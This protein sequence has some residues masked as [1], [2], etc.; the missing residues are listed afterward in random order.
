M[1]AHIPQYSAPAV[2]NRFICGNLCGLRNRQENRKG[3]GER[4]IASG[5]LKKFNGH[6]AESFR[7]YNRNGEE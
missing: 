2:S 6:Y 5:Q 4:E 1:H 7:R 3:T